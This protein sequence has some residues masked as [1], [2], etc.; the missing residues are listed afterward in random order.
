MRL[1]DEK[2]PKSMQKTRCVDLTV[3]AAIAA[4]NANT[5]ADADTDVVG[6]IAPP[7]GHVQ[8]A[9]VARSR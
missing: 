8:H 9:R 7:K 6:T 3:A 1:D 4:N 5:S 2:W